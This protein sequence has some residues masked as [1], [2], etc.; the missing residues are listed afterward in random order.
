LARLLSFIDAGAIVCAPLSGYLLDDVGF[1]P[2]A[3][4]T[5]ALGIMQM[6]LLMVANG[7]EAVMLISF[8]F[9]AVFR[10]FLFPYFFASLSRKIGF[11]YFGMLVRT[12]TAV[13]L[14]LV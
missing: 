12:G 8:V 14:L 7:S 6:V 13:E 1:I 4:I 2:T 5:V 9:Y 10:A 11:K 3:F